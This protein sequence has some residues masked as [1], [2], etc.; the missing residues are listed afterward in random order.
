M[1]RP[2]PPL[3]CTKQGT[4][5]HGSSPGRCVSR[6]VSG[7]Q[8]G[9]PTPP[10]KNKGGGVSHERGGGTPLTTKM[11]DTPCPP[12][13]IF[14]TG[15]PPPH[16][17]GKGG[18]TTPR[19]LPVF[20]SRFFLSYLKR[21]LSCRRLLSR[22]EQFLGQI[23]SR[24]G[25]RG[26]FPENQAVRIGRQKWRDQIRQKRTVKKDY[27]PVTGEAVW[28]PASTGVSV[29]SGIVARRSMVP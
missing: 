17:S 18:G 20:I 5:P 15:P 19:P 26:K 23:T 6:G 11:V 14:R 12:F 2:P 4:T 21:S 22:R 25:S 27:A 28:L 10:P 8:G 24:E 16:A 13:I 7:V 29:T 3:F 9:Y 1:N